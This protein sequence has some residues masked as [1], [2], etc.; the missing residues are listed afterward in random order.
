MTWSFIPPL[1]PHFVAVQEAVTK[2]AKKALRAIL[3]SADI[4]DEE[5]QPAFIGTEALINS[6]PLN[7]P[8][9]D[10]TD[11]VALTP[12]YFIIG[13]LGAPYSLE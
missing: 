6:R 7:Y 2:S 4:I 3:Q 5:L 1:A 11:D 8:S 13:Q 12:N 9:A 10:Y